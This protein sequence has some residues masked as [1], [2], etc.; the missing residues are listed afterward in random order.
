MS[1]FVIDANILMSILISGKSSY[2]PILHHYQ[3]ICPDFALVEID[4]YSSVIQHKTKLSTQELRQWTYS[5]LREI[6]FLPRYILEPEVLQKAR[7]LV[8]GVDEKDLSYVAL[9]MQLDIV[10]LT[11]DIPLYTYARKSGFR[12]MLLFDEF[13]RKI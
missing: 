2:R 4:K 3:F 11:R 5:V 1:D 12:K 8:E 6:T 10:L 9:A 7:N 13:L